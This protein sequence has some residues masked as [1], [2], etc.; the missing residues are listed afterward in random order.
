ME[1]CS[2]CITSEGRFEPADEPTSAQKLLHWH[3]TWMAHHPAPRAL[4][5]S[6]AVLIGGAYFA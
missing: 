4:G 5:V 6:I 1:C 3:T 2:F